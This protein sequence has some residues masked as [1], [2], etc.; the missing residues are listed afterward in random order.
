MCNQLIPSSPEVC[1]GYD[2]NCDGHRAPALLPCFGA[3]ATSSTNCAFGQATCDDD[4]SDGSAGV[5]ACTAPDTG[6]VEVPADLCTAWA[7]CHTGTDA[8]PLSPDPFTCAEE[9]VATAR[10]VCQV[11]YT[12]AAGLCPG[13]HAPLADG[14]GPTCTFAWIGGMN[15]AHYHV[16]LAEDIASPPAAT[17]DVCTGFLF[18]TSAVDTPP[19]PDVALLELTEVSGTSTTTYTR[20]SFVPKLVET[21][22]DPALSCVSQ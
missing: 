5:G 16:G 20:V 17:L 22:A 10:V 3:S 14:T 1:D 12:T 19:K 8:A 11:S 7:S 18:V 15:Q 4:I 9:T 6:A 21:C 2:T 13:E